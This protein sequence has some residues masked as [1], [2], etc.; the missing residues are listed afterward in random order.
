MQ[1]SPNGSRA[2]VPGPAETFTGVVTVTPLFAPSEHSNAGGGLVEFTPGARS[3]WH[4][5]PAGQTL[6][7]TAGTGWVQEE[8]GEKIVIKPGDVITTP[9]GVK[10]WHG[11]ASES[12]M[13]HIA[14]TPARDGKV[15]GWLEPVTDDQY[16]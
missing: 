4:T 16:R 14:I 1:V 13:S 11:A 7:V 2:S 9:P 15:V 8:G 3:H 6:I 5:H 12:P 10:H